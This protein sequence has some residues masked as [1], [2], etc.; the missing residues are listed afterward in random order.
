MMTDIK[1]FSTVVLGF[2]CYMVLLEALD[3][4]RKESSRARDCLMFDPKMHAFVAIPSHFPPA[5]R[6]T[7]DVQVYFK[8]QL[9]GEKP[10][11]VSADDAFC[12][13][14]EAK[15]RWDKNHSIRS[16]VRHVGGSLG[17]V[18]DPLPA[19]VTLDGQL[20]TKLRKWEDWDTRTKD[21]VQKYL[22][23]K[24]DHCNKHH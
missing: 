8:S 15:I 16:F 21:L 2:G 18:V 9:L 20:N 3:H 22:D 12:K 23:A 7:R 17:V 24:C 4:K 13:E 5:G 10:A 11:V 1:A 14:W 19:P 6:V